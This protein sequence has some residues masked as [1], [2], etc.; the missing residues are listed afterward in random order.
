MQVNFG[1]SSPLERHAA[2][3]LGKW[4][5]AKCLCV[6]VAFRSSPVGAKFTHWPSGKFQKRMYTYYSLSKRGTYAI[7]ESLFESKQEQR[8]NEAQ[9]PAAFVS[10]VFT[11]RA[12]PLHPFLNLDVDIDM[13]SIW[14]R[15][16]SKQGLG[17]PERSF[18]NASRKASTNG[19]SPAVLFGAYAE[20]CPKMMRAK[21]AT[22]QAK[23]KQQRH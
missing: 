7:A 11:P 1:D 8:R 15:F 12:H 13:A 22:I 17:F 3:K 2:R 19:D 16:V 4:D 21:A 5:G 14:P 9:T 6:H 18:Q 23:S 20:S 10:L